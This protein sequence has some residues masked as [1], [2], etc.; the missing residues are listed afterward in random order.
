MVAAHIIGN[1]YLGDMQDAIAMGRQGLHCICVLEEEPM[2]E[3]D[4]STCIWILRKEGGMVRADEGQLDV[5]ADTIESRLASGQSVLVHC[6]AGVERGP[7]AVA[8]YLHRKVGM[9]MDEAYQHVMGR[10]PQ[11]QRRD[12]DLPE[13]HYA[14]WLHRWSKVGE[15]WTGI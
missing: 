2:A 9:T 3:P 11:A 10:R 5:V 14:D 13:K 12:I 4:D 6:G 7:L 1:L 15:A 8:W